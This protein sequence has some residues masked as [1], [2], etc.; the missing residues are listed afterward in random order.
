MKKYVEEPSRDLLSS[1]AKFARS[2][3]GRQ[4]VYILHRLIETKEHPA[5]VAI[6]DCEIRWRLP[7]KI[8]ETQSRRPP[9]VYP[10]SR[11]TYPHRRAHAPTAG[12][13]RHITHPQPPSFVH[14]ISV[15]RRSP[16]PTTLALFSSAS[17][18][19]GFC[20]LGIPRSLW[21]RRQLWP[22]DHRAD[23]YQAARPCREE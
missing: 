17:P 8:H 3:T 23:A 5:V 10:F 13:P 11:P 1:V 20:A 18:A 7:Q 6:V 12:P 4:I 21:S 16:D 22:T 19:L 9:D 15:A 14:F 2:L